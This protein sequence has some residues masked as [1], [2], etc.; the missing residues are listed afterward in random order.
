MMGGGCE[1]SAGRTLSIAGISEMTLRKITKDPAIHDFE[2]G[3]EY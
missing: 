2:D 1:K 3:L